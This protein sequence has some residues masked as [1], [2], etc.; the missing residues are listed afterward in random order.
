LVVASE[1]RRLLERV[2]D[3]EHIQIAMMTADDL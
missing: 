1:P 3:L 2:R